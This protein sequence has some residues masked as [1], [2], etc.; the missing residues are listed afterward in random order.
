MDLM[1][2]LATVDKGQGDQA[3]RRLYAGWTGRESAT[4]RKVRRTVSAVLVALAVRLSPVEEYPVAGRPAL[5]E[6]AR[7]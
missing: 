6:T 3:A 5:A 7:G 1:F 2:G 4:G